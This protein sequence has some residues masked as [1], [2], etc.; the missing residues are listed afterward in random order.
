VR[1][2]QVL[3]NLGA[4]AAL[5]IPKSPVNSIQADQAIQLRRLPGHDSTDD[6]LSSN[7]AVC[8]HTCISAR[9]KLT[10]SSSHDAVSLK[11]AF[12]KEKHDV[13]NPGEFLDRLDIQRVAVLNCRR[14]TSPASTKSEALAGCDQF[15]GQ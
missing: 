13:S 11:L 10:A 1:L 8:F 2:S 15:A 7:D 3:G 5:Q 12:P 6:F 4:H 14:H 9:H